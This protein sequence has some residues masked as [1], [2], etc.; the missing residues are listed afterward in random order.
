MRAVAT[1]VA[2]YKCLKLLALIRVPGTSVRKCTLSGA[3]SSALRCH[4]CR[5]PGIREAL[6]ELGEVKSVV[7]RVA[8]LLASERAVVLADVRTMVGVW[9]LDSQRLQ[10]LLNVL[11]SGGSSEPIRDA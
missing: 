10:A 2:D 4:C 1:F 5:S 7:M 9:G 11:E 6:G 8:R 3:L